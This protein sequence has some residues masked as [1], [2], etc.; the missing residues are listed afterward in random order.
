[1]QFAFKQ[2]NGNPFNFSGQP[3][4]PALPTSFSK[5]PMVP[6]DW[7][8]CCGCDY[9]F[10]RNGRTN[11]SQCVQCK[12]YFCDKCNTDGSKWMGVQGQKICLFCNK[13]KEIFKQ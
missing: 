13:M 1:M 6:G 12:E 2:P 10:Q 3:T 7:E 8:T 5:P 9:L 11:L 4:N